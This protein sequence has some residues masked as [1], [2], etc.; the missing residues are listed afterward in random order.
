MGKGETDDLI[1][2]KGGGINLR[3]KEDDDISVSFDYTLENNGDD[4]PIEVGDTGG[5]LWPPQPEELMIDFDRDK[6]VYLGKYLGKDLYVD[7]EINPAGYLGVYQKLSNGK[8]TGSMPLLSKDQERVNYFDR[9]MIS[10][11]FTSKHAGDRKFYNEFLKILKTMKIEK[12]PQAK[13]TS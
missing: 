9:F 13:T 3:Y 7:G 2:G 1:S 5:G 10:A 6:F 11:D 12:I 8:L 4:T